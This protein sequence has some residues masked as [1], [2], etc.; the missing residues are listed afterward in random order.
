MTKKTIKKYKEFFR[1]V[2]KKNKTVEN[3]VRKEVN[4]LSGQAK[5]WF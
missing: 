1:D 4:K 3:F 5:T 2:G